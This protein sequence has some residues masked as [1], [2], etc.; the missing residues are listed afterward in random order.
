MK[1]NTNNNNFTKEK[2]LIL[3]NKKKK[4]RK[5]EIKNSIFKNAEK[6]ISKNLA[7]I[8]ESSFNISNSPYIIY[9]NGSSKISNN[10]SFNGK[11][12]SNIILNNDENEASYEKVTSYTTQNI[13]HIKPKD[14]GKLSNEVS[15][16]SLVQPIKTKKK[17]KFKP[18]FST[19]IEIESYKKYNLNNYLI[20]K[21]NCVNCSC[22]IF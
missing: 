18:N 17:V 20:T 10:K 16:I 9:T 21:S 8:N 6:K 14:L 15:N 11:N 12:I 4:E 13:K 2:V 5:K 3:S 1:I 7:D 22:K 19:I